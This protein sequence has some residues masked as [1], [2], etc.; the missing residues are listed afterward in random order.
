MQRY[1]KKVRD[2]I[3]KFSTFTLEQISRDENG[4]ASSVE[5]D[6]IANLVFKMV[7]II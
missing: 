2:T 1:I 4:E 6:E 7:E 5:K 3:V